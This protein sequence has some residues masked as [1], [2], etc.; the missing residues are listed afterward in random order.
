[1]Q[2]GYHYTIVIQLHTQ[3]AKVNPNPNMLSRQ[4]GTTL[5]ELMIGLAIVAIVLIVAVPSAQNIIIQ[6][7]IVSEINEISGIVQFARA[8]AVDEQLPTIVCPTE[9][10]SLCTTDWDDA[11]M[12]FGDL[13]GNGQRDDN[14][15]LLVGTS[16]ISSSNFVTGPGAPIRFNPDGSALAQSVVMVCHGGKNAKYARAITLTL[17]GRVKMS[18]DADNNGVHEG[19]TGS[20]LSCQ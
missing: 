4:Y 5:V 16:L 8:N 18:Q 12:V 1:M 2:Y 19:A 6:N 10:F 11:K 17:Q 13:N 7:R 14:E 20:P 9:D 3:E 15:E